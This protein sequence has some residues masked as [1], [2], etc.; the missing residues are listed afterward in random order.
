[1]QL[2]G[3]EAGT[4]TDGTDTAGFTEVEEFILSDQDD[5]F[6]GTAS[7][8]STTVQ[9]GA[10]DDSIT[11]TGAA[12]SLDGGADADVFDVLDGLTRIPLMAAV[13]PARSMS[14]LQAM[15]LVRSATGRTLQASQK[16]RNSFSRV[17]TTRLMARL[18]M[19]A[20]RLKVARAMTASL[21]QARA[22]ACRVAL[23]RIRLF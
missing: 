2:T 6:D 9:G 11:G 13:S 15:K 7:N 1:V 8:A 16:S 22:I 17:K 12:D 5:T 21:A 14:N 20:P 4:L 3:D 23:M 10:G 19:Q 18:Q